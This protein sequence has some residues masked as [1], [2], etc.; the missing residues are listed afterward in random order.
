LPGNR[1]AFIDFGMVGRLTDER[2]TQLLRLLF[3]L[4]KK[5]SADVAEVLMDWTG[6]QGSGQ[7]GLLT[8]IEDFADRYRGLPLREVRVGVM[9]AECMAVLRR[10]RVTLPADLSL[11]VKAFI[12][13]EGM[14]RDLDPGF[15]MAGEARPVLEA[16][17]RRHYAPDVV[18]ERGWRSL[19]TLGSL[20]AG[21]PRDLSQLLRAARRGRLDIHVQVAHLR[22]VGHE[23]DRAVSRLVVG[24]V[25]AALIIGSSIVMT[26]PG[27]P[28]LLGLP[29]FG[30]LGFLGAVAGSG[31]LLL[32]IWRSNRADREADD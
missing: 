22:E 31:W 28:S 30:L 20:L 1:I 8:D 10:H 12:S 11:L 14:G 23:L 4:V 5:Q 13:L 15:D 17:M 3:G 24:I 16:A 7:D 2:R 25:V 29:S 27:G 18:L 9:L 6:G 19:R 21:L 26:V 32:S